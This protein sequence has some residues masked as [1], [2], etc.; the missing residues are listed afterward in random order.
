MS[1]IDLKILKKVLRLTL[2][3]NVDNVFTGENREISK[4]CERAEFNFRKAQIY[5]HLVK[6][7]TT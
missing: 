7:R 3:N 2:N 4:E 6:I 5:T 1:R